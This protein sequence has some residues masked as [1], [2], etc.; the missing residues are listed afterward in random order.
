MYNHST[1][2][3]ICRPIYFSFTP[4][5]RHSKANR[6]YS[7]KW[8]QSGRATWR[9]TPRC[10]GFWHNG[11]LPGPIW[12]NTCIFLASSLSPPDFFLGSRPLPALKIGDCQGTGV[13]CRCPCFP[14]Q[15]RTCFPGEER[16]NK[17]G[18]HLVEGESS[19]NSSFKNHFSS[20]CYGVW[21]ALNR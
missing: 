10:W 15:P 6:Q 17:D 2:K 11:P 14:L 1:G 12:L 5:F 20:S 8:T 21:D 13:V 7:E 19:Y 18:W 9:K 4:E 16:I 3:V